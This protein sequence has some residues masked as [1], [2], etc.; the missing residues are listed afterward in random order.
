M[1]TQSNFELLCGAKSL[2]RRNVKTINKLSTKFCE[3]SLHMLQKMCHCLK[4]A[5]ASCSTATHRRILANFPPT[6]A[7]SLATSVIIVLRVSPIKCSFCS[8]EAAPGDGS[9]APAGRVFLTYT[10]QLLEMHP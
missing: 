3:L 9:P 10:P 5:M 2:E 8:S 6:L 4:A 7:V 1:K